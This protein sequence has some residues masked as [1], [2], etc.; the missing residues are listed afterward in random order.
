MQQRT[1]Q[2]QLRRAAA[3]RRLRDLENSPANAKSPGE[4]G[5]VGA[6]SGQVEKEREVEPRGGA[7]DSP[8]TEGGATGGCP[9]MRTAAMDGPPMMG[10][11][12]GEPLP[13]L[14]QSPR[15]GARTRRPVLTTRLPMLTQG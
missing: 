7:R 11:A 3:E 1:A 2:L 13:T 5:W 8:P 9:E 10:G 4:R 12:V 15:P 14:M 6:G